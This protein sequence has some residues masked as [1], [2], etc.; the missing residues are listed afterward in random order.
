MD[1]K[2]LVMI[3]IVAVLFFG[4]LWMFPKKPVDIEIPEPKPYISV[5]EQFM[6]DVRN[7]PDPV[8]EDPIVEQSYWQNEDVYEYNPLIPMTEEDQKSL[9]YICKQNHVP[10]SYALAIIESESGFRAE[11][12]GSCGEVGVFQIHPVNW[13][14]MED[15]DI[16]VHCMTGNLEAGVLMLR[17]ALDMY[18]EMD[19]AT[20]V[21]KCGAGRAK[22]LIDQGVKLDICDEVSGLAMYYE[23]ILNIETEGQG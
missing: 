8:E 2:D 14:R 17:E 7:L 18:M 11:A 16:D 22:E 21:Y 10:M 4:I 13:E 20:M 15:K 5:R 12:V 3:S 1:K 9:Y 23:E 19:K 6:Q